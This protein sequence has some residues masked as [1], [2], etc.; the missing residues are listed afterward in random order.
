MKPFNFFKRVE[1][2]AFRFALHGVE[3]ALFYS[4]PEN[5][6]DLHEEMSVRSMISDV[7]ETWRFYRN[8]IDRNV[9]DII[10]DTLSD[11][12]RGRSRVVFVN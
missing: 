6:M 7:I 2:Y 11:H 9:L 8:N 4:M 12:L 1:E 10:E 5:E 3:V